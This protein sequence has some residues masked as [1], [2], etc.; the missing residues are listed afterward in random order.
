MTCS[1]SWYRRDDEGKRI[2]LEFKLVREKASWVVH[3]RRNE[4]REKY[5]PEEEDWEELLEQLGRN[6]RRGKVYPKD[7]AIVRRL[8][9]RW[10]DP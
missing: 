5:E 8:Y 9:E 3:R 4:P 7:L 10:R 1:V 2:Q 6:L